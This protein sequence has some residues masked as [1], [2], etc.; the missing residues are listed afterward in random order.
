MVL[1]IVAVLLWLTA[2]SPKM[3]AEVIATPVASRA[4]LI[5]V[6]FLFCFSYA[7][8]SLGIFPARVGI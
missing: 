2:E 8:M 1:G 4:L 7:L 5:R 6:L 3:W